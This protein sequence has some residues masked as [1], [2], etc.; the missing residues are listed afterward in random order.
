MP[1]FTVDG[2]DFH[3]EDLND[4]A[5]EK[6]ATL[7]FLGQQIQIIDKEIKAFEIAQ[8]VYVAR[9]KRTFRDRTKSDGT[10]RLQASP[11]ELSKN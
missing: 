9:L 11:V 8:A 2:L 1:K 10:A 3:S 4:A 7:N 6:F 5:R